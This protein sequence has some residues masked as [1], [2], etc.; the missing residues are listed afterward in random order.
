[1]DLSLTVTNYQKQFLATISD[2]KSYFKIK[3]Q[4]FNVS[5]NLDH[6]ITNYLFNLINTEIKN[7][8]EHLIPLEDSSILHHH[9]QVLYHRAV[10]QWDGLKPFSILI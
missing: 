1:M 3:F 2:D 5:A 4:D 8:K 10:N 7:L 9:S 6:N